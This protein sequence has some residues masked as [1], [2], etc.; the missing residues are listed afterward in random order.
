MRLYRWRYGPGKDSWVGLGEQFLGW[1][2]S[3]QILGLSWESKSS[4]HTKFAPT[5]RNFDFPLGRM[6]TCG[7]NA[8]FQKK[9]ENANFQKKGRMPTFRKKGR[10]PTFRTATCGVSTPD[11]WKV[12]PKV[13]FPS[14]QWFSKVDKHHLWCFKKLPALESC[15]CKATGEVS[16]SWTRH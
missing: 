1:A 7:E 9:G 13:N 10:M 2:E 8:N 5:F 3:G 14:M 6:P 15:Y 16:N 11:S 12:L 4:L